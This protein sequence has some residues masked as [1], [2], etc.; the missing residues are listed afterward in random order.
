MVLIYLFFGYQ[1]W[2]EYEAE[3]LIP[4]ISNDVSRFRHPGSELVFGGFGVV[5]GRA[6]VPGILE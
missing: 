2:F 5:D 4:Y 3:T 6:V 1:K